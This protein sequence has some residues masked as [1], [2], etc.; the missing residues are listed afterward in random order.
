MEMDLDDIFSEM[1]AETNPKKEKKEKK[2]KPSTS[3]KSKKSIK[4]EEPTQTESRLANAPEY[5]KENLDELFADFGGSQEDIADVENIIPEMDAEA[6][7][8]EIFNSDSDEDTSKLSATV[9]G[10]ILSGVNGGAF[11]YNFKEATE[12]ELS[13]GSEIGF[14]GTIKNKSHVRTSLNK[15]G[16]IGV[17]AETE[18][19]KQLRESYIVGYKEDGTPYYNFN[20]GGKVLDMEELSKTE[21]VLRQNTKHMG[22]LYFKECTKEEARDMIICGHYSH[23]FQGY[24]GKVNIGVYTEGRLVGVASFG[25]LMNPKSYKNFGD[26]AENEI[27]ELNRLWVDDELGM[28]TETMLLSASWAIMRKK[29]PEIKVVQSFADGR[30]GAGTIYKATGFGYYGCESTLFFQDKETGV[31]YHKVG[32]ENTKAPV[33]FIR[34]NKL[35]LEG[36]LQQFRVNTYRYIYPLYTKIEKPVLD[37]NGEVV[38]TTKKL[39]KRDEN[40]ELVMGVDNKPVLEEV[41]VPKTQKVPLVIDMPEYRKVKVTV[42]YKEVT[43]EELTRLRLDEKN[44]VTVDGEGMEQVVTVVYYK[45]FESEQIT[46]DLARKIKNNESNE[47]RILISVKTESVADYPEYQRGQNMLVDYEHPINLIARSYLYSR[48]YEYT[49][50]DGLDYSMFFEYHLNKREGRHDMTYE[51][52]CELSENERIEMRKGTKWYNEI[53]KAARNNT[54]DKMADELKDLG[55]ELVTKRLQKITDE[56]KIE[57]ASVKKLASHKQ[58]SL[59]A[60]MSFL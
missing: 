29:Y 14:N 43:D 6:N 60:R 30:L 7:L 26:F 40:G 37:S 27:L 19:S 54:L 20:E 52:Y 57:E 48:M 11:D 49:D 16:A 10:D 44:T 38:L 28:N 39:A 21:V 12:E 17:R 2:Q 13:D 36:R 56:F 51:E 53:K 1:E 9:L 4:K 33:S 45:K 46:K 59:S 55:D 32:I 8:T 35:Y 58:D 50:E 25:G 47:N 42:K 3:S 34:L 5:G 24:F 23:K 18:A 31:I 15:S 22:V 41:Q